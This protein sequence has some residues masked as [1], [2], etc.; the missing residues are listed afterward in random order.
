MLAAR[1]TSKKGAVVA[2]VVIHGGGGWWSALRHLKQKK[3]PDS[4]DVVGILLPVA[5]SST[6][7]TPWP[8]DAKYLTAERQAF[9]HTL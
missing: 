5:P 9:A 4:T 3:A 2:A 6:H 8:R 1:G 7:Q